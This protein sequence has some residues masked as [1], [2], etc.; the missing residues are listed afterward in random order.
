M[1]KRISVVL[2]VLLLAG[3]ETRERVA[4]LHRQEIVT[5]YECDESGK[6]PCVR[7]GGHYDYVGWIVYLNPH[8]P[9]YLNVCTNQPDDCVIVDSSQ[10]RLTFFVY[11]KG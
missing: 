4:E 11:L 6:V 3:C 5:A 2:L 8:E 7:D 9:I 1:L 10:E